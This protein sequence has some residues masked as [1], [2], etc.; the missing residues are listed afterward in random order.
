MSNKRRSRQNSSASQPKP[1]KGQPQKPAQKPTQKSKT[2]PATIPSHTFP[3]PTQNLLILF[4]VN[5]IVAFF[6]QLIIPLFGPFDYLIGF[7]VGFIAILTFHRPYGKRA[8]YLTYF[9]IYVLWAMVLSNLSIAKLVLQPKPHLDPGIIGVPLTVTSGL[10]ITI[11]ASVITL[12]PGTISVDL[13]RNADGQQVLYVHNLTVVDP[14][15][16]RH[17]VKD[18]F[19]RLLLRVT[20]GQE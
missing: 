16:F 1:P 7:V 11:L 14:D 17:S 2:A 4:L 9:V 15:A 18:G 6:W 20:Q 8:Y 10:E 12:T 3:L 19:E 5:I 13:G